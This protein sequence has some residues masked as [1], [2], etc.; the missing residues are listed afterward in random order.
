MSSWVNVPMLMVKRINANLKRT[1]KIRLKNLDNKTN[2]NFDKKKQIITKNT[3]R[4]YV[5]CLSYEY[6]LLTFRTI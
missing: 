1:I 2:V 3:K 4:Y 6:K 5:K